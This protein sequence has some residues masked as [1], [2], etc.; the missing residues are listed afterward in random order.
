MIKSIT[1]QIGA[2]TKDFINGLK[3]VDRE[4]NT[5]K[6]TADSLQNGLKIE[7]DEKRFVQAQKAYQRALSETEKQMQSVR[8]KMKVFEE[9]GRVDT[10]D[11]RELE[12][13]LAQL[14]TKY[15][16]LKQSAKELEDVNPNKLT[17]KVKEIG[18]QAEQSA[19]K[20][21]T[22]KEQ[23]SPE[24]LQNAETQF[25]NAVKTLKGV[26]VASAGVLAAAGASAKKAAEMGAE[27]DDLSLR[28]GVSAETMEE[29]RYVAVQCGVESDAFT[30]SLLKMRAGM[31]DLAT[32]TSNNATAALQS[33]GISPEQFETQEEMFD[34]I[35][36]A[37]AGVKDA[38]LQTA[39]ANDIFGDK[40][41]TQ[42]LPYINTGTE[43]IKQFKDEFAAMPSLTNEQVSTL[44]TLDDSFYRLSTTMQYATAQMGVALAPVMETVIQFIEERFVPAITSLANWFA[45]LD[46][47]VQ[48]L[49]VGLLAVAA[50]A[51]P[52]LMLFGKMATGVSALIKLFKSLHGV[53]LKTA[54]GFAAIAGA[55]ALGVDIIAN[56]KNMSTVEKILKTLAMAALVAAAAMTVFHSSWSMGIAIGAIAAAVAAGM[57]IINEVKDKLLP[58]E[59]DFTADNLEG[60]AAFN[61]DDYIYSDPGAVGGG[62]SY[63]DYYE[64]N[65]QINVTVNVT[66]PRATAEEIAEA[67]SR[68]V[69]T[70]VQARR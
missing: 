70:I 51:A 63:N 53:Q 16:N 34:G 42:M 24:A 32:G 68:E 41:A 1:V 8:D 9:S 69:A 25:T 22:L 27:L 59:E 10:A 6:K 65:A 62:N 61:P 54:A 52:A 4:I 31:A 18:N 49:I 67:V 2:D 23:F 44:A 14:E 33:L 47:W 19:K 7:F 26:S 38:T 55:A 40:I 35:I 36:A 30:K 43:T 39:Y 13:I 37:L 5:T 11:Y 45:G 21:K 58:G 12:F 17:E 66:E 64:D 20:L 3:K 48:K 29:W 60:K 50:V 57:G 15:V 28:Y 56:W 46:P